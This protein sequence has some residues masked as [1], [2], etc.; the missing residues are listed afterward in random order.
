MTAPASPQP[1]V[2][3]EVDLRVP[4]DDAL[5][6]DA[7]T[8]AALVLRRHL[9]PAPVTV[10]VVVVDR[11]LVAGRPGAEPNGHYDPGTRTIGL[12]W[13]T[14]LAPLSAAAH[15]LQVVRV[16]AHEA[17]HAVQCARADVTGAPYPDNARAVG[18]AYEADPV[19][20]E[21]NEESFRVL[22]GLHP[23]YGHVRVPGGVAGYAMPDRSDYEPAW[24]A[25]REGAP[26]YRRVDVGGPASAD[27][28]A[29]G[30][31]R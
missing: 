1:S 3:F 16:A 2:T 26:V 11:L 25:A 18:P 23:G 22:A 21:A 15:G 30:S 19:E 6:H 7:L 24:R 31:A 20:V 29:D 8:A 10:R 17:M 5:L 14:M 27:A 12:A 28:H 13:R 4:V 9:G